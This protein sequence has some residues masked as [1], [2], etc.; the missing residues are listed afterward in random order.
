MAPLALLRWVGFEARGPVQP[1]HGGDIARV[2]RVGPYAV[3][4]VENA[5][6]G[7]CLAEVRGLAALAAR[8]VRVPR[9]LYAGEEGLV[10][11]YLPGGAPAW[12]A[13]A[14]PLAH[15]HR[16]R[17]PDYRAEPGFLGT[18]P[19]PGRKGGDWTRFFFLR[20]VEPLLEAPWDRLKGLGPRV[21]ALFREPL[22]SEGPAP[23]HGDLWRGNLRFTPEGPALLDPAFFLGKRA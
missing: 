23:L 5:P 1:L 17:E 2:H 19:L 3:K 11:E 9:V 15:L 4:L 20:Y 22:P 16:Q 8:E 7:L 14:E 12:G 21:A 6:P 18:F 13:L 10:L